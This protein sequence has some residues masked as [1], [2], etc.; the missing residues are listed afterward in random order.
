MAWGQEDLA[1]HR[2][3]GL[4]LVFSGRGAV[5]PDQAVGLGRAPVALMAAPGIMALV[6]PRRLRRITIMVRAGALVLGPARVDSGGRPGL[7]VPRGIIMAAVAAG[8]AVSSP[9]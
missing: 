7:R 9:S 1:G 3:E 4:A 5:R 8:A 2:Q 6:C